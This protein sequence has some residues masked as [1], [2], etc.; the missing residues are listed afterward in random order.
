MPKRIILRSKW[1]LFGCRRLR[2][3][4]QL[5]V[6]TWAVPSRKIRREFLPGELASQ[7]LKPHGST[8]HAKGFATTT[9]I[10]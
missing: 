2:T 4:Y 1:H 7:E 10:G 9:A 8:A 5:S 6:T 3:K